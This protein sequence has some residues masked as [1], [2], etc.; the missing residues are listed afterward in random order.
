[1]K[2]SM[3]YDIP[4]TADTIQDDCACSW[5]GIGARPWELTVVR[6]DCPHHGWVDRTELDIRPVLDWLMSGWICAPPEDLVRD[7]T[8]CRR[9]G[10][11]PAAAFSRIAERVVEHATPCWLWPIVGQVIATARPATT[12]WPSEE[13]RAT[14]LLPTPVV[15]EG[16]VLP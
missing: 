12:C 16:R 14:P 8:I 11:L 3:T 7:V 6:A 9:A 10:W 13:R 15:P 5:C 4:I 2:F 1:M